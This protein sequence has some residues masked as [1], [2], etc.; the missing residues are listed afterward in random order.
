MIFIDAPFAR[1]YTRFQEAQSGNFRAA[2]N[3]MTVSAARVQR[4]LELD[5]RIGAAV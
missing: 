3:P 2:T 5:F 4:D 1:H